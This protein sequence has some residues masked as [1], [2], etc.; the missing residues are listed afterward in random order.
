MNTESRLDEF[1]EILVLN[2]SRQTWADIR[3]WVVLPNHYHILTKVDLE[4]FR[5]WIHRVHNKT[6]TKWNREDKQHKRRVWFRFSDRAIRG[7][8]HYYATVNYIHSNPVKHRYVLKAGEWKWSSFNNYLQEY[9]LERLINW[10]R[11]Y[12]VNNYG[13]GWDD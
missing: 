8:R 13:K 12:P 2:L 9:G 10:W 7:E 4:M 5:R 1:Y 6:S 3:A 11:A